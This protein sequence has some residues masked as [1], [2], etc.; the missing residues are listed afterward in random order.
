MADATR[1]AW[2]A[3]PAKRRAQQ[4]GRQGV[5]P[6]RRLPKFKSTATLALAA[7]RDEQ[8]LPHA[9]QRD[10]QQAQ[11]VV[12]GFVIVQRVVVRDEALFGAG[13]T[14]PFATLLPFDW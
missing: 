6:A 10:V 4:L 1:A 11:F 9:R 8:S 3:T 2:T 14:R 12:Q 13:E 7:I 5:Q